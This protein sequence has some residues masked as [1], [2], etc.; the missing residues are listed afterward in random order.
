MPDPVPGDDVAEEGG[1][2]GEGEGGG[3]VEVRHHHLHHLRGQA[4]QGGGGGA[5]GEGHAGPSQ[6]GDSIILMKV[7]TFTLLIFCLQ[8]YKTLIWF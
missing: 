3:E 8:D 1:G 5:G 4:G 7:Q 6:L 2:G